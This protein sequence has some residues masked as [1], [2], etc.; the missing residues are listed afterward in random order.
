V[1]FQAVDPGRRRP[2]YERILADLSAGRVDAV[3][4]GHPAQD[5]HETI[6]TAIAL[7]FFA[8][9]SLMVPTLR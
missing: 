1:F 3:I 9:M 6:A 5:F 8:A 7:H 2:G 4:A